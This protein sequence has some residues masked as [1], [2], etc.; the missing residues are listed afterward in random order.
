MRR[1]AGAADARPVP[2]FAQHHRTARRRQERRRRVAIGVPVVVA[3]ALLLA[4]LFGGSADDSPMTDSSGSPVTNGMPTSAPTTSTPPTGLAPGLV[5]ALARAQ[6][7][8]AD[9]GH[10][11]TVNS[12]FRTAQAQAAMLDAEVAERGS[13]EEALWWVFPPERS[14]HVQGLAIDIGNGPGA[15]WLAEEGARFGLCHTLAWEWWHFEWRERWED[16]RSCP[17]PA[18]T[19]AEAPGV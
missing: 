2:S 8:A 9:A 10:T 4:Q 5:D 18:K 19:P 1:T 7:A 3:A 12:G 13:L 15:D 17:A 14:M 6:V 16:E 11:L